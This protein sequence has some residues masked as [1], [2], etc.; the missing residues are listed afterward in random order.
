MRKP[1]LVLLGLLACANADAGKVVHTVAAKGYAAFNMAFTGYVFIAGNAN[2]QSTEDW[3]NTRVK[4][5]GT[6]SDLKAYCPVNTD[7]FTC[8]VTLRKNGADGNS[9]VSIAP[10]TTGLVEDTTHSDSV[11]TDDLVNY[12]MTGG[13]GT[14]GGNPRI[15][16]IS[17]TFAASSN[18]V[19][20]LQATGS[21]NFNKNSIRYIPIN[22][23]INHTLSTD[24]ASQGATFKTA[25]TLQNAYIYINQNDRTA[26]VAYTLRKNT[27]DTSIVITATASTT[28]AFQDTTHTVALVS[29]DVVNWSILGDAAT[30]AQVFNIVMAE[31]VTTDTS[32]QLING[33]AAA[34]GE[35][36]AATATYYGCPGAY[37]SSLSSNNT[38]GFW[39]TKSAFSF[40]ALNL[41]L[42]VISNASVTD[43]ALTFAVNGTGTSLSATVTALTTG[44]F[45]DTTHTAA[46]TSGDTFEYQYVGGTVASWN[47]ACSSI[48]AYTVAAS[49]YASGQFFSVM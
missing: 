37:N 33:A 1:L 48:V 16:W 40:T 19:Q 6:F 8:T 45:Q 11:T 43:G 21:Q 44:V 27:A 18:T 3:V 14:S 29:D 7:D 10:S 35:A 4:S 5:A 26:S 39:Q 30:D 15:S 28:G 49:T 25:G 31:F 13:A 47:I 36:I 41:S 46:V 23:G 17:S 12:E 32:F 42:N 22:G 2:R 24:E 38:Q 34:A 9:I 20:F